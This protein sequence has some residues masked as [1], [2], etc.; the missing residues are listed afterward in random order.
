MFGFGNAPQS[1]FGVS[2]K[3]KD[4][5][6]DRPAVKAMVKGTTDAALSR[7]GSF[8]RRTARTLIGRPTRPKTPPRPPGQPVRARSASNV[9]TIRNILFAYDPVKHS[10]VVGPVRL[11][12]KQYVGGRL[13]AG[14]VPALH[15]FGGR[16]GIRE[17]LVGKEWRSAGRRRARPNQPTRVR[18]A[19]Y[20]ARPFMGPALAENLPKFPELWGGSGGGFMEAA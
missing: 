14:T 12:Q 18:M 3:V 2:Y 6:F 19:T 10:V 4:Y 5:F 11:N 20:P 1:A 17:K 16:V 9:A 13:I 8:V 15:E 7:A